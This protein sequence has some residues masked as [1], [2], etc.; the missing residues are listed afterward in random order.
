ME[1]FEQMHERIQK[2]LLASAIVLACA[3]ILM[4]SAERRENTRA[5]ES[6]TRAMQTAMGERENALLMAEQWKKQY[7]EALMEIAAL[8]EE[9]ELL[10]RKADDLSFAYGEVAAATGWDGGTVF[11]ITHYCHCAICNGAYAYG[12]TASGVEPTIGRTVAVDPSVIPLGSE[13]RINGHTYIAEDTGVQGQTI[14]IFVAT[15]AEAMRRGAYEA[16]VS[17]RHG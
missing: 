14:D 6:M 16:I 9:N 3:A 8:K 2:L 12:P 7:N 17:W 5:M 15:H 10:T 11:R 4:G 1:R 13:V